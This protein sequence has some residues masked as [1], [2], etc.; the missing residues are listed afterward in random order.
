MDAKR[1]DKKTYEM[2]YE[3]LSATDGSIV[4]KSSA[5]VNWD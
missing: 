4:A 3:P 2:I 1:A 5:T